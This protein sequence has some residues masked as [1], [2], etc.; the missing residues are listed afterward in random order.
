LTTPRSR[1][2]AF[3]VALAAYA[4]LLVG[5]ISLLSAQPGPGGLVRAVVAL[6]PVPAAVALVIVAISQ[7]LASDELEQRVQL[8]GLGVAFLGT[9]LVTFSW[10]FL[11]GIGFERL[12]GFAT[13][14]VL[15]ALYVAGLLLAQRRYR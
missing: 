5:S 11:E 3:G 15:V 2:I 9:L 13:F 10:G 7:F 12:P 4:A 14:G 1:R 6:L 8:V